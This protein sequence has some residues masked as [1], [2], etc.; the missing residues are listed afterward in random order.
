MKTKEEGE[1]RKPT[2]LERNRKLLYVK[3]EGAWI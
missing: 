3:K 1:K 2:N